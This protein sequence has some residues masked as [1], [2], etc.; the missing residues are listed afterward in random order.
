[1]MTWE[2]SASVILVRE[3]AVEQVLCGLCCAD[4]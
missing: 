3:L 2:R 1:M 4:E